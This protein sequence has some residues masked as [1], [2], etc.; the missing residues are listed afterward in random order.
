[1]DIQ[2]TYPGQQKVLDLSE[3]SS[4]KKSSKTKQKQEP[5]NCTVEL[6]LSQ[7]RTVDMAEPSC[8]NQSGSHTGVSDS[9]KIYETTDNASNPCYNQSGSTS[10]TEESDYQPTKSIAVD[11]S[12][13]SQVDP[14]NIDV[15]LKI[16]EVKNLCSLS[17]E[18]I[19][20]SFPGLDP[21]QLAKKYAEKEKSKQLWMVPLSEMCCRIIGKTWPNRDVTELLTC[22][23]TQLQTVSP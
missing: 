8:S 12:N 13:P 10:V 4:S 5:S 7:D 3:N 20:A 16:R 11:G 9:G 18:A 2:W 19:I 23:K 22:M 21:M 14:V 17:T 1:M 15:N 6:N